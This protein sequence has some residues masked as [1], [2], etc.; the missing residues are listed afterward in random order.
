MA[1]RAMWSGRVAMPE[2]A[3]GGLIDMIT[4]RVKGVLLFVPWML[5]HSPRWI[6]WPNVTRT[7]RQQTVWQALSLV[8]VM[9]K[10]AYWDPMPEDWDEG[11]P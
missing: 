11:G 10:V 7:G 2:A 9:W 4:Q 6:M 3:R 8:A 5:R 1:D